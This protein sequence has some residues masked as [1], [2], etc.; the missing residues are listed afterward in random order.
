MAFR[1][2]P[3]SVFPAPHAESAAH[4]PL[5]TPEGRASLQIVAGAVPAAS[6]QRVSSKRGEFSTSSKDEDA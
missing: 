4:R 6:S 3:E 2:R 5:T 1:E